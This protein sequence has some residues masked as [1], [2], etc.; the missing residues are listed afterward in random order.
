MLNFRIDPESLGAHVPAG[1]EL[2][3]W[4]GHA[5]VSLVGFRFLNT[6]IL[7]MPVPF[8]RRFEEVNLR[9][10]VRRDFG[11]EVRRGVTF[12]KET[13]PLRAVT[14][15]AR[16]TFNEP[17]ETRSMRHRIVAS[18]TAPISAEYGWQQR[19]GWGK[20]GM[21]AAASSDYPEPGSHEEFIAIRHWGYTR[22]RDGSTVEYRVDHSRWRIWRATNHVLE[23]DL[24]E[25]YGDK[26]AKILGGRPASAFLADG[27]AVSVSPPTRLEDI[28]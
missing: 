9:F 16:L 6:R 10:Y 4:G 20:L 21:T 28:R 17:Y 1:T 24:S 3:R 25:M 18:G 23:G 22:Q 14:A 26:F 7:R 2:D 8:H 11:S 5:Y 27:S 12:I 19:Q 13:V 15:A